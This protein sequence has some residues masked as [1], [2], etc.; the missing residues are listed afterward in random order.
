[1]MLLK[2]DVQVSDAS[3]SLSTGCTDDAMKN[4]SWLQII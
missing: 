2:R 4:Y 3:A 1:M